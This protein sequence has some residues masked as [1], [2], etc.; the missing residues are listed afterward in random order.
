MELINLIAKVVLYL[1]IRKY[2][3]DVCI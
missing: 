1:D 3:K 2:F